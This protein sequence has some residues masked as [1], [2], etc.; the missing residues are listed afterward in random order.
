MVVRER[1]RQMR[2]EG[3]REGDGPAGVH[4]GGNQPRG[5][6]ASD[7]R[8]HSPSRLT[9]GITNFSAVRVSENATTFTSTR[10]AA[11][12][13]AIVARS[14]ISGRPFGRMIH[15]APFGLSDAFSFSSRASSPAFVTPKK[16]ASLFLATRPIDRDAT[17]CSSSARNAS[18]STP[19]ADTRHSGFAPSFCRREGGCR[20]LSTHFGAAVPRS[21]EAVPS[22]NVPLSVPPRAV[23][24]DIWSKGI[25][26]RRSPPRNWSTSVSRR[27][28]PLAVLPLKRAVHVDS[29]PILVLG[30]SCLVPGPSLVPGPFLVLSTR[31]H[32]YGDVFRDGDRCPISEIRRHTWPQR[33]QRHREEH[34]A[35]SALDA[36]PPSGGR[37]VPTANERPLDRGS[38][39]R[40]RSAR[41]TARP[42]VQA[43]RVGR[44][45]VSVSQ[46]LV[47]INTSA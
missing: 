34:A 7:R 38:V 14:E 9:I 46:W 24:R 19:I 43:A 21:N 44:L 27:A 11:L 37:G 31:F 8:H 36:A 23:I 3:R 10:P 18:S 47:Q 32:T 41:L 42:A 12:P 22:W 17:T 45:C 39:V 30:P 25:D 16:I 13:A 5:D 6:V 33:T 2:N 40:V 28:L 26:S 29:A 4:H 15:S 35:G 20:I 1:R